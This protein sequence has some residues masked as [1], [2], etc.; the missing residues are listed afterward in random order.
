MN[1]V[2]LVEGR[3][4]AVAERRFN[5]ARADRN[6]ESAFRE[7]GFGAIGD[8]PAG[9][10]AQIAASAARVPLLAALGDWAICAADARR[11]AWVLSVAQKADPH[12]AYHEY[13]KALEIDH[14]FAP[15]HNNLGLALKCA[16]GWDHVL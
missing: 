5:N 4:N 12:A 16:G 15:T 7:T 6:Y 1:R 11:R 3:F 2:T 9:A 13:E 10:A 14:Q 8:D